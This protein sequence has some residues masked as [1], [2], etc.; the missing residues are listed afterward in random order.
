MFDLF[1]K[2]QIPALKKALFGLLFLL[3][4]TKNSYEAQEQVN[5]IQVQ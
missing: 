3:S 5:E 4:I 1:D 2:Y